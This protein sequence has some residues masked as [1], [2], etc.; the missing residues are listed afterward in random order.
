MTEKTGDFPMGIFGAYSKG[1]CTRAEFITQFSGWQKVHGM[2]YDCKI[3]ANALGMYITYRGVTALI[4]K[5]CIDWCGLLVR[6]AVSDMVWTF[7]RLVDLAFNRT[8]IR[9]DKRW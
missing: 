8:G 1:D 2:S 7:R 6:G 4:K 5:D 9:G 3:T